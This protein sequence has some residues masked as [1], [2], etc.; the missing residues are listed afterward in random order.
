MGEIPSLTGRGRAAPLDMHVIKEAGAAR[1]GSTGRCRDIH[2][3]ASS[4]PDPNDNSN[5]VI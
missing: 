1:R 4:T 5:K 2:M 3:L